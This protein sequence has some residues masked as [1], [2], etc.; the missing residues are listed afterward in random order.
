MDDI[1]RSFT[2]V[3]GD[4]I[5]F[6]RMFRVIRTSSPNQI[7]VGIAVGTPRNFE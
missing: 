5:I 7:E 2:E 6:E 3:N 1:I 4:V